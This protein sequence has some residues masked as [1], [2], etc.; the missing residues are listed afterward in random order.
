[1]LVLSVKENSRNYMN[2]QE[3]FFPKSLRTLTCIFKYLEI[4]NRSPGRIEVCKDFGGLVFGGSFGLPRDLCM[5]KIH[6]SVSNQRD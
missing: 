2:C 5:P 4:P 6:Y 3:I 1:M